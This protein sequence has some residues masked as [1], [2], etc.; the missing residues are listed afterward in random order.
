M[1]LEIEC[2]RLR[3]EY[4]KKNIAEFL[5]D[6]SRLVNDQQARSDTFVKALTCRKE[7]EDTGETPRNRYVK[8]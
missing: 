8:R 2:R 1:S 6:S 7:Q 5:E 3:E 4:S